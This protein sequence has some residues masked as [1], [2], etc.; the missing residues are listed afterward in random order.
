[1]IESAAPQAR[2]LEFASSKLTSIEINSTF[3]GLQKPATFKKWH[4]ATPDGFLVRLGQQSRSVSCGSR[5]RIS[6]LTPPALARPAGFDEQ[7]RERIRCGGQGSANP[8]DEADGPRDRWIQR[9]SDNGGGPSRDRQL[10]HDGY[11]KT[12]LYQANQRRDVLD[13][14]HRPP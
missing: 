11:A 12:G 6:R 9:Y 10:R 2:E 5:R 14:A 13:L 4:D 1:M 8:L 3:Y 7:F